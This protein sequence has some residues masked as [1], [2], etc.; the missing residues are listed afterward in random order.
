M[1]SWKLEVD[2]VKTPLSGH[3]RRGAASSSS[4]PVLSGLQQRCRIMKISVSIRPVNL[5]WPVTL[6]Y[7]FIPD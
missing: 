6:V 3:R 1:K 7:V 4:E 2:G 5:I